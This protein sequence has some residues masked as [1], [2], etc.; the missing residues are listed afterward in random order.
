M[1]YEIHI[2]VFS[3]Y[4]LF[5]KIFYTISAYFQHELVK[6]DLL[7]QTILVKNEISF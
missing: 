3:Q 5:N 6:C 7:I 1:I 2:Y 4:I